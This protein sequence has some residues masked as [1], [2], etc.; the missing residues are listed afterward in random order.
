MASGGEIV[1]AAESA[2]TAKVIFLYGRNNPFC[3]C[4]AETVGDGVVQLG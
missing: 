4:D 3:R 2:A 1:S